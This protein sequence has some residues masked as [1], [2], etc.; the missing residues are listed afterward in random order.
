[1]LRVITRLNV[2]GPSR[3]AVYLTRA[4]AERG[5][6]CRL[7]AG[8]PGPDEGAIAGEGEPPVE[9]RSLQRELRP[10]RDLAA[11]AALTRCLR[12]WRPDVV[13]THQAKAGTLGRTAARLT[14]VPV[15][16]HTFYGHVLTGYFSPARAAAFVRVERAIARRTDA[17]LAVSGA[18]R[19][20]LLALGIGR[21]DQWR[22]VP[23]GLDLS[24]FLD[25]P[26]TPDEQRAA[27]GLPPGVPVVAIAA[28]LVPVKDVQTFLDAAA[29]IARAHP[30]ALFAVAGDG[31]LRPVLEEQARRLLGDRVR[32]LGWVDDLP[33][34]Y[35]AADVVVL[36]SRNEG[37]PAALIEAAAASRPV[38]ATRVGG[39]A[40]VVEHDVT[41]VLCDRG[42]AAAIAEAV[43]ALLAEPLRARALGG[44]G[45]Q[46]V[47]ERFSARRLADDLA[48]LYGELLDRKRAGAAGAVEDQGG[49]RSARRVW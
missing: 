11:L 40:D 35:G 5:F 25:D 12:S 44:A 14:S 33:A 19:D 7:A 21:P 23:I 46:R 41:G 22:V 10:G 27:L 28:R 32:F 4:L 30:T 9:I 37:T 26:R 18:I 2:G 31:E 17:L 1:M 20:E 49:A 43:L 3:Q 16:V 42:D 15:V 38:V 13:H 29:R 36:T 47:A 24:G 34:L 48:S 8:I 6:D 45:R 39:V